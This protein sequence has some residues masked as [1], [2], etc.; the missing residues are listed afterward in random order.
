MFKEK[1]H[2]QQFKSDSSEKIDLQIE[3][4]QEVKKRVDVSQSFFVQTITEGPKGHT[5]MFGDSD[6]LAMGLAAFIKE[7]PRFA[8]KLAA[9]MVHL[10]L[11]DNQN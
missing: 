3:S 2:F 7:T 8:E 11:Q 4:I 10:Q 5:I 1:H 6:L 9:S